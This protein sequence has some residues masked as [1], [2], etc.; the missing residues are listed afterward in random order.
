MHEILTKSQ[1]Q[2]SNQIIS[3]CDGRDAAAAADDGN[4]KNIMP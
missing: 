2:M 4:D 3:F 1:T